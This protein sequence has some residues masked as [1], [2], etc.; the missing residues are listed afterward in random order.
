MSKELDEAYSSDFKQ[1][2]TI[3]LASNTEF[4]RLAQGGHGGKYVG[5]YVAEEIG[6]T[7]RVLTPHLTNHKE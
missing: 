3:A 4:V 5:Y 1:S 2:L 6:R 7:L